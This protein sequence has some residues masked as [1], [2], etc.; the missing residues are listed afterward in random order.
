MNPLITRIVIP[1]GAAVA[2]AIL[3]ELAERS[4]D[5]RVKTACQLGTVGLNLVQNLVNGKR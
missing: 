1:V 2:V 3:K 5:Q 4:Q